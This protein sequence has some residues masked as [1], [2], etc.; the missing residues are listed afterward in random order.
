MKGFP[1]VSK[2]GIVMVNMCNCRL[3][4]HPVGRCRPP[5]PQAARTLLLRTGPS[6]K[7]KTNT[8]TR[9]FTVQFTLLREQVLDTLIILTIN[10]FKLRVEHDLDENICNQFLA[11]S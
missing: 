11:K 2:D 3:T 10:F 9:M 6:Q 8:K 7:S 1:V 5:L 4:C